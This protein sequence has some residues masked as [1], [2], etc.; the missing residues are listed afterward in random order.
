MPAIEKL[1]CWMLRAPVDAPVVNAFGAMTTRP[2]LFVRLSASDGAWG[3]GEVWCNFPQVGGEHRARLIESLF[4]PLVTGS[5]AEPRDLAALLEQLDEITGLR[6][7]RFVTS[8][9]YNLT[10]RLI[11]AMRDVPTVCE[12]LHLP[13]QSGSNQIL[14]AMNRGY[15]RDRYLEL[16]AEL[17]DTV[18]GLA[19]TTDLIVG[20]PGETEEDFEATADMVERIGYDGVFVF[21]YSRRPGTPAAA[22]EN[23]VPDDVK[24]RRNTRLLEVAER[25]AFERHRALEGREMAILVDGS[26]KRNP[27]ELSG[28]TRCNR[29]VNFDGQGRVSIGDIVNVRITQAMP[30]SLRGAL[31]GGVGTCSLR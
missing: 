30:H 10:S 4:V 18:P 2:A 8:N 16:V 28:R 17:R 3:W 21:R 24:A 1:E 11:H 31:V 14:A 7:L 22:F 15:T 12:A 26:S 25:V 6:R 19:L 9:P 29:V 13:L 23:Q 5:D 27:G 20:F